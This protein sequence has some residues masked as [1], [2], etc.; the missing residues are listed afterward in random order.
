MDITAE[1]LIDSIGRKRIADRVGVGLTAV[2]NAA[3]RKRIPSSW[4]AA[5]RALAS[6]Q[7]IEC[8]PEL[9]GQKGMPQHTEGAD[10]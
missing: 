9:F 6:D 1:Q 8:P 3:V 7:G 10:Q 2:S 5:C 4:Y